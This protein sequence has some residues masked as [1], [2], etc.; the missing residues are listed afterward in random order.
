MQK[1]V[2]VTLPFSR[3][4]QTCKYF[5]EPISPHSLNRTLVLIGNLRS[6]ITNIQTNGSLA[7]KM[8]MIIEAEHKMQNCYWN[9]AV[10]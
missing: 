3:D 10:C 1:A 5:K 8:W 9:T 2:F 7:Y 4:V 6:D